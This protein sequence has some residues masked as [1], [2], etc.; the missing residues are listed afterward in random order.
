M[1]I[2]KLLWCLRICKT[3][4]Q[5]AEQCRLE[6]VL[7]NGEPV[8]ASRIAKQGDTINI[9]K[10]AVN[11]TYQVMAIPK[12]RLGP[13]MLAEYLK[14]IT[15]PEEKEKIEMLKAQYHLNRPRGLGRPTKK[16]RRS[17]ESFLDDDRLFDTDLTEE[18]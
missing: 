11:Y 3:R 12:T 6:K 1:R 18:E 8:K 13:K 9:R 15:S 4:S 17:I 5:A 7:L 14:D 16:E 10:G 2:D